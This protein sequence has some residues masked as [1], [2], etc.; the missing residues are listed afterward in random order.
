VRRACGVHA[1][2]CAQYP[3]CLWHRRGGRAPGSEVRA[4]L[5]RGLQHTPSARVVMICTL[6]SALP[7]GLLQEAVSDQDDA[8]SK[9]L[10]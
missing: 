10:L 6:A 9:V 1:D 4:V 8:W 5:V 7:S 3:T 2:T